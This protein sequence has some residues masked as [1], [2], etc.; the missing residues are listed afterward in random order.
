LLLKGDIMS[1]ANPNP[2]PSPNPSPNVEPSLEVET[3]PTKGSPEVP[4]ESTPEGTPEEEEEKRRKNAKTNQS[5]EE[6]LPSGFLEWLIALLTGKLGKDHKALEEPAIKDMKGKGVDDPEQNLKNARTAYNALNGKETMPSKGDLEKAKFNNSYNKLLNN[7]VDLINKID[8]N[9]LSN[10]KRFFWNDTCKE[11]VEKHK[12]NV[13]SLANAENQLDKRLEKHQQRA[14]L[15]Q[16]GVA[17]FYKKYGPTLKPSK[18]EIRAKLAKERKD[19]SSPHRSEVNALYES[20]LKR[21]E[22]DV[23]KL[24]GSLPNNEKKNYLD[25]SKGPKDKFAQM[26]GKNPIN[27]EIEDEHGNASTVV[28][29]PD[30]AFFRSNYNRGGML[31]RS[32]NRAALYQHI[33]ENNVGVDE[34]GKTKNVVIHGAWE[35]GKM[36]NSKFLEELSIR[37]ARFAESRRQLNKDKESIEA[38]AA[39]NKK[40]KDPKNNPLSNITVKTVSSTRKPTSIAIAQQQKKAKEQSAQQ[41]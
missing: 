32:S 38:V 14:N 9:G 41:R 36:N 19:G 10:Y 12:Q 17:D 3:V 28:V 4:T 5:K 26:F 31:D 15:I 13:A 37:Q 7:D 1:E 6:E 39:Y 29:K 23:N 16:G 8:D 35:S 18:E 27:V 20:D 33:K 24:Y 2:N 25:F 34:Q 21:W 40:E 22:E 30:V 11:K